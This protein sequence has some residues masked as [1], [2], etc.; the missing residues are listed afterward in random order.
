MPV[1]G[2]LLRLWEPPP[3]E[4]R[5]GIAVGEYRLWAGVNEVIKLG[6]D[7]KSLGSVM[8]MVVKYTCPS[9]KS[10]VSVPLMEIVEA[11]GKLEQVAVA[12]N[13]KFSTWSPGKELP[14]LAT[15]TNFGFVLADAGRVV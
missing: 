4:Y 3:V 9:P 11:H 6:G 15:Y 14:E 5:R 2:G 12:E 8:E 1:D 10:R 7:A 13:W